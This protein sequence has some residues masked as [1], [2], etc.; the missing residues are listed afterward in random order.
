[1]AVCCQIIGKGCICQTNYFILTIYSALFPVYRRLHLLSAEASA[2]AL[3]SV[4]AGRT[5]SAAMS[6]AGENELLAGENLF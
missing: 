2:F 5:S 3:P 4:S 1:M 6:G